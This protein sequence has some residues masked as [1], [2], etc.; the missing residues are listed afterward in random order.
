MWA[1]ARLPAFLLL[2]LVALLQNVLLV[3][4]QS[5][6]GSSVL[7]VLE[8]QLSREKFTVFFDGLESAFL[9]GKFCCDV[10]FEMTCACRERI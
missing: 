6:T 4:A 9:C 10:V 1:A 2:G 8:P 3:A 5:S 7:V